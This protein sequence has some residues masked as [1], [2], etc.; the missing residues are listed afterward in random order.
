MM[1]V[2]TSVRYHTVSAGWL[3]GTVGKIWGD[4][5]VTWTLVFWEPISARRDGG[6]TAE[7]HGGQDR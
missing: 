6:T 2:G 1:I 3:F 4:G 7:S 5:G